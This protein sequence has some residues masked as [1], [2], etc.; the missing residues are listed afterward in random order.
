MKYCIICN[1]TASYGLIDE[2]TSKY[3]S[4]CSKNE[5]GKMVNYKH[6]YCEKVINEN[7]KKLSERLC[8]KNANFNYVDATVRKGIR[9][10]EHQ[11]K[12]MICI[13]GH[14][15]KICKI[16][17]ASFI[18]PGS[19]SKTPTHCSR[20]LEKNN[21]KE[22]IDISHKKC[23]ECNSNIATYS[24]KDKTEKEYCKE[25][26]DKL[27]LEG[28]DRHHKKCLECNVNTALYNINGKSALYCG[29]CKTN[30]ME[31][32]GKKKCIKCNITTPI[33]NYPNMKGGKYCKECSEEGMINVVNRM[34]EKCNVK[35]PS[36]NFINETRPI[37]CGDCKTNDMINVYNKLCIEEECDDYAWYNYEGEEKPKYCYLHSKD[38]MVKFMSGICIFE[39]C[40]TIASFNYE[41]ETKRLYCSEHLLNGMVDISHK[42]CIIC[43]DKRATYNEYGKIERLYCVDHKTD[44]MVNLDH[45][46]CKTYLCGTRAIEHYED[47]CM[48]CFIYTYPD[49]PLSRNYKVKENEVVK[50]VLEKFKDFTWKSD[51][52]VKDG[53]SL[54]RPDLLLDLGYQ[55]IN[56]EIDENQHKNYEEICENKRLM[57]IS[58]DIQHR[59]LVL[60]RFNPDSYIE[61]GKIHQSCWTKNNNGT[62]T[63]KKP[64]EKIWEKRLKS[65]EDT[66]KYWTDP[67]NISDKMINIIHLFYDKK[68][69]KENV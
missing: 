15:C 29:D 21:I 36:F 13:N 26:I 23:K 46:L 22:K 17:I 7:G 30:E 67:N 16:T 25:C 69:N 47:Y 1:K 54:K 57:M 44:I 2:Q 27:N 43:N 10:H 8:C 18:L 59:N 31:L 58:Q 3:C 39:N 32:V 6:G 62:C 68:E 5:T 40:E 50:Y 33:F 4:G 35:R 48:R 24:L 11:E 42:K 34:C 37:Y 14:L 63:I 12:D 65:L 19:K 49:K 28:V 41:N 45:K 53:C 51:Q 38:E 9:C 55:V 66:I 64:Y 61:N 52:I 20:C 56:I 60:I